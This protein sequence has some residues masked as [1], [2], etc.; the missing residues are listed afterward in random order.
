[1]L[2]EPGIY[3]LKDEFFKLVGISRAQYDR[4]REDLMEWLKDFYDYEILEGRPI[5]IRIIETY[6]EYQP[7]PRQKKTF[8]MKQYDYEEYVKKNL[9]KNFK[10][11]SKAHMARGAIA[12]FGHEKYNHT[13]D[14]AVARRYTGPAMEKYG[15]KSDNYVWVSYNTYE[16][17]SEELLKAW[18]KILREERIGEKEAANAFYKAEQGMDIT[19][20]KNAYKTALKR[21]KQETHEVP[22]RVAEWKIRKDYN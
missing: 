1:M 10:P 20:E 12:D 5:R 17:L 21:M 13:N 16:P 4:R 19:K 18:F 22:V 15:E 2:I 6:G 7:L 11:E 8:L 9:S 3:K 14:I